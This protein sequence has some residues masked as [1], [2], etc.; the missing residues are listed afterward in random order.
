MRWF[1]IF[2]DVKNHNKYEWINLS[3]KEQTVRLYTMKTGL[4][5]SKSH[6][7]LEQRPCLIRFVPP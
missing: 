7:P 2:K 6:A 4:P 1:K 3:V 5:E